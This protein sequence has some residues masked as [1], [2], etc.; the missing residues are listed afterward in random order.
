MTMSKHLALSAVLFSSAWLF[1]LWAQTSPAP[2]VGGRPYRQRSC[3]Q[4]AGISRSVMPRIHQIQQTTRS[5]VESVCSNNSLTP[6]QKQQETEQLQQ[7]AQQQIG[8][9]LSSEQLEA[10]RSCQE[11]RGHAGAMHG[12]GNPCGNVPAKAAE[13][14][15]PPQP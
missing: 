10:L 13:E 6:E 1:P 15:T 12:G 3:W 5:Q 7:Q 8:A 2:V 11:Q 14:P 9:L 4:Q